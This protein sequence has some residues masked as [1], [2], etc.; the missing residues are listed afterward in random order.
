MFL[1]L[2]SIESK[3][4]VKLSLDEFQALNNE[5]VVIKSLP[6]WLAVNQECKDIEESRVITGNKIS[7]KRLGLP[8]FWNTKNYGQY[9]IAY[10]YE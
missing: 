3:R 7:M 6:E 2:S 5:S 8:W 4:Q 9:W 10:R 1:E